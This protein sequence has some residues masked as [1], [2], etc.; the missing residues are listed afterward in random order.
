MAAEFNIPPGAR[1]MS[2]DDLYRE[3]VEEARR[4]SFEQKLLGGPRLFELVSRLM[5]D[6]IRFH[7]PEATDEEVDGILAQRLETARLLETWP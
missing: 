1:P 5:I 7:N 3:E 6:G 4:E 2:A